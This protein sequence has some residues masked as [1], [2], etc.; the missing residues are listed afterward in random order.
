MHRIGSGI[1]TVEQPL[2]PAFSGLLRYPTET[3]P[4]TTKDGSLRVMLAEKPDW[5]EGVAW[6]NNSW[7][8]GMAQHEV[9]LDF[10]TR[11]LAFQACENLSE[12]A[13]YFILRDLF[14]GL[15]GLRGEILLHASSILL[16]DGRAVA[17]CARSGGGKSTIARLLA[18]P[19]KT[20]AATGQ[21]KAP[22]L[23]DQ[24][25][26][27]NDEIN[28]V[29][30]DQSGSAR[31]V[32]QRCWRAAPTPITPEPVLAAVYL[33]E[34]ARHCEITTVDPASAY[35]SLLAAPFGRRD[36]MLPARAQQTARLLRQTPVQLLRF[37]LNAR[38]IKQVITTDLN[39]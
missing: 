25:T 6:G 2:H 7:R 34:Q 15:G 10:S 1:F 35:P 17:F 24:M 5:E 19:R 33:L 12:V 8:K 31:L 26:V 4:G 13:V 28:W 32:N 20:A 37:N 9:V 36:P 14:C 18:F 11:S 29:F 27:V 16:P 3:S 23:Q 22:L 39:K 21:P 38:D 30:F